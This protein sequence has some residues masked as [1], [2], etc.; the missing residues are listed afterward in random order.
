MNGLGQSAGRGNISPFLTTN[1]TRF[2]GIKMILA[3]FTLHQFILSGFLKPFGSRTM[4]F[5]FRHIFR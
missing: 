1:F 5:Y 4:S 3:S 2:T